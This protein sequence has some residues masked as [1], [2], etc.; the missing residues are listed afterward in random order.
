MADT[1]A[2]GLPLDQYTKTCPPGW[3][4]GM[5]KYPL[6]RYID[7]LRLWYRLTD[8]NNEQVGPAAAGRLSGRPFS[9]A[10]EMTLQRQNGQVLVG[11]AALAFPGE[12]PGVD[13]NGLALPATPSG[14]QRVMTVLQEKYGTEAQ[15]Q[16]AQDLD[17][18]LDLRRGRHTLLDFA[19]EF[20]HRYDQA[21][22]AAG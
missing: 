3:R 10:T 20:E 15:D 18:F 2:Q 5:A 22:Q 1:G 19:I 12:Q 17:D 13:A 14:L 4:L 9:L 21:P 11:D 6:K 8:F 16:V 7:L